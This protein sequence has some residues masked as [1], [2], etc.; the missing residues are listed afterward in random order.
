MCTFVSIINLFQNQL[1]FLPLFYIKL[2]SQLM[3]TY[4]D[5][6]SIWLCYQQ[7]Q[8]H[9]VMDNSGT[10]TISANG[11]AGACVPQCAECDSSRRCLKCLS[12]Q[13]NRW[14]NYLCLNG[15]IQEEVQCTFCQLKFIICVRFIELWVCFE[16]NKCYFFLVFFLCLFSFYSK[17]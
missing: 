13:Y 9:W 11:G 7:Q 4:F 16:A 6:L 2:F 14:S 8:H 1:I 12:S 15:N 3:S 10:G 17:T 5:I